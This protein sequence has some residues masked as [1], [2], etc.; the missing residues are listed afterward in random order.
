MT[1]A[2]RRGKCAVMSAVMCHVRRHHS[3]LL[4]DPKFPTRD[5]GGGALNCVESSRDSVNN[6]A[7]EETEESNADHQ[8]Y[9]EALKPLTGDQSIGGP[10][11]ANDR[12]L[13]IGV[14]ALESSGCCSSP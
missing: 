5:A 10:G 6:L 8:I 13:T 4:V 1:G 9:T 11:V 2:E 12:G 3:V 7:Q 14:F